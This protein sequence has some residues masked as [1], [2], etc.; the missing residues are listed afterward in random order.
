[1][2]TPQWNPVWAEL[3]LVDWATI[4]SHSL[5]RC[6]IQAENANIIVF[7]GAVVEV[8]QSDYSLGCG[9][10]LVREEV[11]VKGTKGQDNLAP[12]TQQH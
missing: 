11:K 4:H 10:G 2:H 1:M 8:E 7:S 3:K 9:E 5:Y 6:T 12:C